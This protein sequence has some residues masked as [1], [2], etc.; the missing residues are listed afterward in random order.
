M[1]GGGTALSP[2]ASLVFG[3][4]LVT[5]GAAELVLISLF[6]RAWNMLRP[7]WGRGQS[8]API[9]RFAGAM[10]GVAFCLGGA[11]AILIGYFDA[12]SNTRAVQIGFVAISL[13]TV[14]A[15]VDHRRPSK[16]DIAC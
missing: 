14:A 2:V 8:R 13:V 16:D 4:I 15:F 11:T 12:I 7:R 1:F 5:F 3:T 10:W 6:P 9:S